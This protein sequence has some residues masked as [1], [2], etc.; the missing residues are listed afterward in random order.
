MTMSWKESDVKGYILDRSVVSHSLG[1]ITPTS[2]HSKWGLLHYFNILGSFE[3]KVRGG[4]NAVM[5]GY[6]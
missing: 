3:V 4:G 6:F 1:I 2:P 5:L